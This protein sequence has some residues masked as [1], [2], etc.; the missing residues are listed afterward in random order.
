LAIRDRS[1]LGVPQRRRFSSLVTTLRDY[2]LVRQQYPLTRDGQ[3]CAM[4]NVS[5]DK[6]KRIGTRRRDG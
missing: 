4:K 1:P 6:K 5:I 2:A 3:N